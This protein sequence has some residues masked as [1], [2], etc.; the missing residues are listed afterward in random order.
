MGKK[1]IVTKTKEEVLQEREK[2]ERVLKKGITVKASRKIKEGRIYISSSF[3]NTILTLTDSQG[4]VLYWTSAGSVGFK[5]TRRGT[6]FAA[7]KATEV[8][9]EAI[10]KLG[11]EEISVFLKGVGSGR[12]SALRSL[13][14]HEVNMVSI[15]DVTPLPHNG[16]RPPKLRRR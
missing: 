10:K 1:R 15:E 8:L 3:N 9:I 6:P 16:C 11:I 13:A 7:L 4:N 14:G 12:G 2:R 5:G